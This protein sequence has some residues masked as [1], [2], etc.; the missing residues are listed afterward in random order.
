M[1]DQ[2][3]RKIDQLLADSAGRHDRPGQDEIRHRQERKGIELPEHLLREQRHHELWQQ[4][5]PDEAD[6]GDAKQDRDP[7]HHRR[8]KKRKEEGD[9]GAVDS[10]GGGSPAMRRRTT[11]SRY[12]LPITIP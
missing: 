12:T 5:D 2:R 3:A 7:D 6:Q 4:R 9:H 10:G 11:K 8:E 1:T